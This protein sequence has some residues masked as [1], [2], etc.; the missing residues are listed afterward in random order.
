M[1]PS[2]GVACLYSGAPAVVG[3]SC[4]ITLGLGFAVRN[5]AAAARSAISLFSDGSTAVLPL[6]LAQW[7]SA[8]KDCVAGAVYPETS[9]DHDVHQDT[10]KAG[11]SSPTSCARTAERLPLEPSSSARAQM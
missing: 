5:A 9:C 7:A 10:S 11:A 1:P 3:A 8:V 4:L 2:V 6:T